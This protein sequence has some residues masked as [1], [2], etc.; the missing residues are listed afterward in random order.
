MKQMIALLSAGAMLLFITFYF[1]MKYFDG[2]SVAKPYNE[3]LHYDKN[4]SI[5]KNYN[6]K[7]SIQNISTKTNLCTLKFKILSNNKKS[8]KIENI[9]ISRPVENEII[10]I[11]S[12]RIFENSG[13]IQFNFS[14]KGYYILTVNLKLDNYQLTLNKSFYIN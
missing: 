9:K 11:I 4:N 5:I 8:F 12:Y 1:G 14:K 2:K 13:T 3:A 10:K 6:L 7:I